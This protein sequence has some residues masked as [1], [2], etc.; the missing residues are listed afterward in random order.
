[1]VIEKHFNSWGQLLEEL[2]CLS[3]L[4]EES[5]ED[6]LY[7]GQSDSKWDLKTTLERKLKQPVTLSRYYQ[8]AYSAKARVETFTDKEWKGLLTPQKYD[9][10]IEKED[11][12]SFWNVPAYDYLVYLRHHGFPSPFLDWTASP[13]V[14]AFFAFSGSSDDQ[15]FVSLYCSLEYASLRKIRSNDQPEIYSLGPNIKAHRRHFL[16]QSQYTICVEYDRKGDPLYVNHERVF[17]RDDEKQDRLW[18]FN[19]PKKERI[20]A[21][22]NLNKMN[23]NSYS[24]FGSEDSLIE[25][26]STNEIIKKKY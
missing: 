18:K 5:T 25:T 16:Q 9:Q 8:F 3:E 26:I 1:M 2:E 15:E 11:A 20:N 17:K 22:R 13:Y 19:I 4:C 7:R 6:L 14:A 23:I 21:L 10:W 24:L 12:L